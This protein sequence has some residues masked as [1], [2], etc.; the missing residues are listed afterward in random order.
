MCRLT[1]ASSPPFFLVFGPCEFHEHSHTW[2]AFKVLG[3]SKLSISVGSST[4]FKDIDLFVASL[5]ANGT[6]RSKAK[7]RSCPGNHCRTN[8][9]GRVECLVHSFWTGSEVYSVTH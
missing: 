4:E 8:K 3:L 1:L 5:H 9:D 7:S 6:Q 2:G